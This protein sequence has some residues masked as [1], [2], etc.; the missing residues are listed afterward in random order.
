MHEI[1]K[2]TNWI[3]IIL[4]RIKRLNNRFR[5]TITPLPMIW[6]NIKPES[7]FFIKTWW[8]SKPFVALKSK[9]THQL[10]LIRNQ[11][12]SAKCKHVVW[13]FKLG[14]LFHNSPVRLKESRMKKDWICDINM[15]YDK[16]VSPQLRI[17]IDMYTSCWIESGCL[18]EALQHKR[19]SCHLLSRHPKRVH[20]EGATRGSIFP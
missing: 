5:L 20:S 4:F 17:V 8:M 3:R 16:G 14:F 10:L 11:S 12:T 6:R 18:D 1:F 7:K 15:M 2:N 9:L 19:A 13:L